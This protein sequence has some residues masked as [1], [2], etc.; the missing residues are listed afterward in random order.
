MASD[1]STGR[2]TPKADKTPTKGTAKGTVNGPA[3]GPLK[4]PVGPTTGRYT[5]PTARQNAKLLES[6]PWLA[7]VMFALFFVGL[8][9]I[10]L[11]LTEVLP[12][13][14]NNWYTLGGLGVILLGFLAA[15]KLH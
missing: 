12:G 9:T 15:T 4:D 11:N 3:Q 5:P 6:P 13:A 10:V 7:P 14:S 2:F 1:K 8:A